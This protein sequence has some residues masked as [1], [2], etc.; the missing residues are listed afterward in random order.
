MPT[1][2]LLVI[3]GPT[4]VGKT[5]LTLRLAAHYDCPILNADSRQ[6]YREIPIGTAAP[7]AEEQARAKHYFVGTKAL[8][9]TYNAGEFERDC[10]DLIATLPPATKTH[11]ITAILSG[12]SMLYIDAVCKGLDDIPAV[13]EQVRDQVRQLYQQGGL[14]ALQEQ[15]QALD[16]TYWQEVDQANPQRLMHCIEV[17]MAAGQPYSGFRT[18]TER[19]RPFEVLM[20][21]VQR[22][23]EQLYDRINRRVE[24]MMAAGL[25]QEARAVWQEPV[26]NGLNTVGYK[27]L[28]AYFRGETT[29]EEAI[30]QI[31]QNTRHYAKRQMTWYRNNADIHWLDGEQNENQQIRT[32]DTW[33]AE[34][35]WL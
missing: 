10:L 5:E 26:P 16:P 1:Q 30:Q 24:Q 34:L 3:T 14:T 17:S 19:K 22:N 20:V 35:G 27:E 13:S 2:T 11:P 32:V 33:L 31:Q 23:R 25:E 21:G 15:V 29:R 12:G 18:G 9:E 8:N 7:T 28:F 4:G 6:I